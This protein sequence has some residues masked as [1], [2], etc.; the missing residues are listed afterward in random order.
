[1]H[2]FCVSEG[3]VRLPTAHRI[4][5]IVATESRGLWDAL[6]EGDVPSRS[7]VARSRC[8]AEVDKEKRSVTNIRLV[9]N[10]K[11]TWGY[12]WVCPQGTNKYNNNNRTPRSRAQ[13]FS[14]WCETRATLKP[15]VVGRK[16]LSNRDLCFDVW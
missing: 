11:I 8:F 5:E 9:R 6:Y 4:S 3:Y 12:G 7:V 2:F 16:K 14:V 15:A 10:L 13:P 1:M